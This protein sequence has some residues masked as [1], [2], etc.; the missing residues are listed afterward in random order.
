[1]HTLRNRRIFT[2][3][4]GLRFKSQHDQNAAML[5][6]LVQVLMYISE[7]AE[8][9][10]QENLESPGTQL[11]FSQDSSTFQH[12]LKEFVQP[13]LQNQS[14][15]VLQ[16][17]SHV[18]IKG[19]QCP[20]QKG[21]FQ[22]GYYAIGNALLVGVGSGRMV[23]LSEEEDG[24][25]SV[26]K[27]NGG[28][29]KLKNEDEKVF[30]TREVI[31]RVFDWIRPKSQSEDVSGIVGTE[32]EEE[33][34]QEV[35]KKDKKQ[36][37]NAPSKGVS[38][39]LTGKRKEPEHEEYEEEESGMGSSR[40]EKRG[41]ETEEKMG[42]N[43]G[44]REKGEENEELL[45]MLRSWLYIVAADQ[46]RSLLVLSLW[47]ACGLLSLA[48]TETMFCIETNTQVYLSYSEIHPYTHTYT[49]IYTTHTEC[50][51]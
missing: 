29:K 21:K 14:Y 34:E 37:Q 20:Q 46:V 43:K 27:G 50:N 1:M 28:H 5:A 12:V 15:N 35:H 10:V 44:K 22:C 2:I 8:S 41:K 26:K 23:C 4:S 3:D 38:G 31:M 11:R 36:T 17:Y 18:V 30:L 32:V 16:E 6:L 51:C 48:P 19:D 40:L 47:H 9:V 49:Y 7:N 45:L 39:T 13:F 33:E 25:M 24:D 42:K